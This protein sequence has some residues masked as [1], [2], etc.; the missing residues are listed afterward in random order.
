[1][2]LAAERALPVEGWAVHGGE[3]LHRRQHLRFRGE[4]LEIR[5]GG[6]GLGAKGSG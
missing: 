2:K 1:L 3:R 6:F 5:V 4:S